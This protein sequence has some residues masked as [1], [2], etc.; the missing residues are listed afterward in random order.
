MCTKNSSQNCRLAS[1][2]RLI[3]VFLK[4]SG[5]H[6]THLLSLDSRQ[7]HKHTYDNFLIGRGGP[8]F[9]KTG[10]SQHD[11]P[12]QRLVLAIL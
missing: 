2:K 9:I 12:G 11:A 6:D 3:D 5:I 4:A 1:A 10:P 7:C 8:P